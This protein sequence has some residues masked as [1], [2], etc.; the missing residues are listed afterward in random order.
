MTLLEGIALYLDSV[1]VATYDPDGPDGNVFI[2]KLPQTPD[3]AIG[4][5]AVG[6]FPASGTHGYDEPSISIQV[7]GAPDDPVGALTL[8]EAIYGALHGLHSATLPDGS[9]VVRCL[10]IQSGPVSIGQDDQERHELTL[11]FQIQI[12]NVT[13]HRE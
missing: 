11:N 7:R 9:R 2:Q 6:G 4:I 1:D 5:F 12:R 8:A 3:A 10:G 13:M